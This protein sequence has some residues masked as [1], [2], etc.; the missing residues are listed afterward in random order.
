MLRHPTKPSPKHRKKTPLPPPAIIYARWSIR[1]ES[2]RP[3]ITA[4]IST[5]SPSIAARPAS[6]TRRTAAFRQASSPAARV[7]IFSA[8]ASL[9]RI[10]AALRN[11]GAR[12]NAESAREAFFM[13]Q[14]PNYS[15]R[16]LFDF[17][18]Q[19]YDVGSAI[20]HCDTPESAFASG[21]RGFHGR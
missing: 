21:R 12:D 11:Q 14:A 6:S 1:D 8:G 18:L 3:N 15:R 7:S 13:E 4:F 2:A 5:P 9:T 20:V 19:P 10:R 17:I 16:Q